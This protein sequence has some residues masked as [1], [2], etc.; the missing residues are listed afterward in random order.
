MK[1]RTP[2]ST[3][4]HATLVLDTG[5]LVN[6]KCPEAAQD[7]LLDSLEIAVKLGAWW[8]AGLI[9]GCSVDY[10]GTAMERVNMSRVVGMA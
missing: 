6:I 8:V 9:E 5:E 2:S 7:Q 10:R 3:D 1:N 4:Y